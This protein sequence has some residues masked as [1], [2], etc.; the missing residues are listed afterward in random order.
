MG[1]GSQTLTGQ[2]KADFLDIMRRARGNERKE[3]EKKLAR[4][5][6][7]AITAAGATAAAKVR[8]EIA[9]RIRNRILP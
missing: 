2:D 8:S 6:K 9:T 7:E 1:I 3:L 5:T 4:I